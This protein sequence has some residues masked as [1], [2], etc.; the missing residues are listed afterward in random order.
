MYSFDHDLGH[1]VSI[2]PAT[3]SEDGSVI[4]SDPGVGVVKAGWHC[5]GNPATS[6]TPHA[7]PACQKCSGSTCVAD[8]TAL[9]RSCDTGMACD[10]GG[11]CLAGLNL[12]PRICPQLGVV[13]ANRR[14]LP[15][16][17]PIVAKTACRPGDCY[18]GRIEDLLEVTHSCDSIALTGAALEEEISWTSTN[19][20]P[21]E[22]GGT[23]RG[24]VV[25]PGNRLV[26]IGGD[27][28]TPCE[29]R[30]AICPA[31]KKVPVGTCTITLH[32][33]IR[34]EDCVVRER[35]TVF[36]VTKTP[37]GGCSAAVNSGG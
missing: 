23:G 15:I 36:T 24:C 3:V 19:G 22:G 5:G 25:G 28:R 8:T 37:D 34:L 7:C 30:Q 10:G 13:I 27:G 9:C 16:D 11:K 32:Q 1:F 12:I 4:V 26:R 35:T 20:C 14:P 31:P 18:A 29:D 17:D 6:G 33:K 21:V 2:G